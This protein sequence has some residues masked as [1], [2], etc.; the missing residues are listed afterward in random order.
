MF[1]WFGGYWLVIKVIIIG[2]IKL[3]EDFFKIVVSKIIFLLFVVY[4]VNIFNKLNIR[5]LLIK[6]LWLNL[7]EV[8]L[9]KMWMSK[10][11]MFFIV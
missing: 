4:K 11:V 9:V 8:C 6:M 1:F 5:L 10:L 2:K 7:L 3:L